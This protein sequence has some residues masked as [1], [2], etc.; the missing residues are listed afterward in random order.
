MDKFY[1]ICIRRSYRETEHVSLVTNPF[2]GKLA[3]S[4]LV[5]G[6]DQDKGFLKIVAAQKNYSFTT[7]ADLCCVLVKRVIHILDTIIAKITSPFLN[8]QNIYARGN[9]VRAF[10]IYN[11]S[12]CNQLNA[13]EH[14]IAGNC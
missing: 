5:G 12:L 10:C 14:R 8:E 3:L 13:I 6:N 4:Y 9:V 2:D 7:A 11:N 1:Q